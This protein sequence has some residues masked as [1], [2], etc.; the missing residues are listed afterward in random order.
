LDAA[1]VGVSYESAIIPASTLPVLEGLK[2]AWF[3]VVALWVV[4]VEVSNLYFFNFILV[5]GDK[6]HVLEIVLTRSG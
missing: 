1:S 3:S 6:I 5:A 2:Y 4:N